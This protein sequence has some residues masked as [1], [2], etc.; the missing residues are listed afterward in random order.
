MDPIDLAYNPI[1]A[2]LTGLNCGRS[3]AITSHLGLYW[4]AYGRSQNC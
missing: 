1:R 2:V 4:F 3:N